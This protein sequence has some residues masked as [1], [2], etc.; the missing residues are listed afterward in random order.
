MAL[1]TRIAIFCLLIG[2]AA[3]IIF[4]SAAHT[5][6]DPLPDGE[7]F[8]YLS[9]SAEEVEVAPES[10]GAVIATKAVPV[11]STVGVTPLPEPET[12][13]VR[14]QALVGTPATIGTTNENVRGALVNIICIASAPLKSITGSGV[15]IDSS[16]VVLTNAHVAQYFLLKDTPTKNATTCVVRTGS[17][18]KTMYTAE[19][20]YISPIWIRTNA[21]QLLAANPR[22]TGENDYALVQIT[23]PLGTHAMPAAFASLAFDISPDV[24]ITGDTMVVAGYPAGL[25]SGTSILNNLVA[26]TSIASVKDLYTFSENTPDLVALGGSAVAQRGSSGGAVVRSDSVLAGLIV[27]STD[28]K[29]TD[30]REMRAIT[31][32]HV[33]ESLAQDTGYSLYGFLN[34][35]ATQKQQFQDSVAPTLTTLLSRQLEQ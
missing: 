24:S 27:T 19:L 3:S 33:N 17:P 32:F 21:Y 7:E 13:P 28:G 18:A 10:K 9:S 12:Q 1:G 23:G 4:L 34:N 16:G 11:T 6:Q 5:P 29:T 25:L 30:E 22:G 2:A 8:A 15:I 35:L 20:A 26:V 14:R 31:L